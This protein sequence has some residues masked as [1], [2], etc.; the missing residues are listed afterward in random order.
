M[1]TRLKNRFK[2]KF[3]SHTN[4]VEWFTPRDFRAGIWA[5]FARKQTE[6]NKC[7]I[8]EM[9]DFLAWRVKTGGAIFNINRTEMYRKKFKEYDFIPTANNF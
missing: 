3:I 1:K 6:D 8:D 2:K 5:M 4:Y 9:K 7:G